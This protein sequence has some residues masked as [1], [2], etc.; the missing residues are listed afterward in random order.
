[1]FN[2]SKYFNMYLYYLFIVT[3]S[4]PTSSN[5]K[6]ISFTPV[7]LKTMELSYVARRSGMTPIVLGTPHVSPLKPALKKTDNEKGTK[8]KNIHFESPKKIATGFLTP[9]N[10]CNGK[11][12]LL[13]YINCVILFYCKL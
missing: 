1:M 11:Y 13:N 10:S 2:C 5:Q 9:E 3:S 6:N 12:K 7:L 4:T 8:R